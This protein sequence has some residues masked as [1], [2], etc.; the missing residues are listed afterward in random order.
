[1]EILEKSTGIVTQNI[2]A[3]GFEKQKIKKEQ[4]NNC[5]YN[6]GLCSNHKSTPMLGI[7]DITNRCNLRC[8]I[9]FAHAGAAGYVYEPSMDQ[10]ESMMTNLLKTEPFKT[11]CL[12]L[13][14][15]EPTV[16]EELPEIILMAKELGFILVMVN[17]NGIKMA[18]SVDYC[19]ELKKADLD[20]VYLQFDGVSPEPYIKARGLDLLSVKIRAIEN[21]KEAGL[22]S[23]VLVP[24]I[25]K[26]INDNQI[27][28]II[29][30]A[31]DNK[32]CIRGVNFQPVS[33]TGRINK[34]EREKMRITIPE[35][36]KLAEE[37]TNGF[38]KQRYWYPIPAA[39]P[40]TRLISHV[41]NR[42]YPD[43]NAHPHCGAATYLIIN[44]DEV[45]P[46]SE[47][48][49]I[50]KL[51]ESLDTCNLNQ[52]NGGDLRNK[53][54]LA[55]NVL[56]GIEFK[57]LFKMLKD[58]IYEN[59]FQ[60]V[61]S[62]HKE[63]ILISSMHF[64]DPYNLD[65]DRLQNCVIHYATPDNRMIPFCAMNNIHREE[66]EK[67]FALHGNIDYPQFTK[68][69]LKEIPTIENSS[70]RIDNLLRINHHIR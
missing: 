2:R 19:K 58:I 36:T 59:N 51:L 34:S 65:L 56:V 32:D 50:E 18:E 25:V 17:S 53:V 21:L 30:F 33:I 6:C 49:N 47:Y 48:L 64:Q 27:G 29:N 63:M 14:R 69:N 23:T 16:R 61:F 54:E 3:A 13:S 55:K 45:H 4:E 24:T 8:P 66:V 60:H 20:N 41:K 67:K 28:D 37:Q 7:I 9:C 46:I 12:Q 22:K 52:N 15:G 35:I 42:H 26:G 62:I 43:F 10:I 70:L 44:G 31:I 11:P 57:G 1:M 38:L 40:L 5:P 39:Q 68:N